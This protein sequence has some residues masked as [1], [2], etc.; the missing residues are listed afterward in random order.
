M[1]GGGEVRFVDVNVN[2]P[3]EAPVVVFCTETVGVAALRPLVMTQVI[4]A[5]AKT[6]AAGMVTTLPA[7]DPN[8]G[9]LPVIGALASEQLTA[10]IAKLAVGVSVIVTSVL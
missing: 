10:E 2:G 5:A 4:C 1:P 7:N 6:F 3:P 9:G 8:V